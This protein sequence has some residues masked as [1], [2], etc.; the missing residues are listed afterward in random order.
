MAAVYAEV[1]LQG[2]AWTFSNGDLFQQVAADVLGDASVTGALGGTFN[3]FADLLCDASVSPDSLLEHFVE[4]PLV[5]EGTIGIGNPYFLMAP[6]SL[7][8][9]SATVAPA[10]MALVA[11]APVAGDAEVEAPAVLL[12]GAATTPL[13]EASVAADTEVQH[14]AEASVSG[15]GQVTAVALG[16]DEIAGDIVAGSQATGELEGIFLAAA[17]VLSTTVLDPHAVVRVPLSV[18]AKPE[19]TTTPE[20]RYVGFQP[21]RQQQEPKQQLSILTDPDRIREQN[22]EAQQRTPSPVRRD[23]GTSSVVIKK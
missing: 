3:L 11:A 4:A 21:D 10:E 22:R 20:V 19:E 6:L 14:P 16:D 1:N 7:A 9:D 8:G 18:P 23:T 17:E 15:D 12:L 2:R 5:G 13:G